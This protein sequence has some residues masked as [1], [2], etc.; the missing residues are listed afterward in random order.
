MK[1]HLKNYIMTWMAS[2]TTVH[3]ALL[4]YGDQLSASLDV[5]F[6]SYDEV[7]VIFNALAVAIAKIWQKKE[8]EQ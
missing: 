4:A 3:A 2:G 6:S 8:E 5:F 7:T 1:E